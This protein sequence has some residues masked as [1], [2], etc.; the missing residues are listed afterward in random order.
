[1]TTV[2]CFWSHRCAFTFTGSERK[3]TDALN[4]HYEAEHLVDIQGG[5]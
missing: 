1:M 2:T 3:G 5:P 4:A